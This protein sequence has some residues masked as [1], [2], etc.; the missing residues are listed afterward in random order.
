[1]DMKNLL[2]IAFVLIIG[3]SYAQSENTSFS[4]RIGLSNNEAYNFNLNFDF[5]TSYRNSFELFADY[6]S[7]PSLSY[8]DAQVGLVYK[9]IF[10]RQRNTALHFRVGGSVGT[11]FD[12]FIAAPQ[13]GVEFN[14]AIAG[15]AAIVIA[16]SNRYLFFADKNLRWRSIIENRHKNAS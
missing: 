1:M 8:K 9:P 12:K 5:E 3:K 2:F 13:L 10:F 6:Y 4:A 16:N 15:G 7:R 14:Q 11:D